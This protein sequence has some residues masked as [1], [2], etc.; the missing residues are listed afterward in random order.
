MR[1]PMRGST[2]TRSQGINFAR[3]QRW[4]ASASFIADS[5]FVSAELGHPIAAAVM[6][7]AVKASTCASAVKN[8][9]IKASASAS[10]VKNITIK[11]IA[12]AVPG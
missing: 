8:I 11:D 5:A 6:L 1:S 2:R 12:G 3:L 9:T 7:S 10:A 4:R